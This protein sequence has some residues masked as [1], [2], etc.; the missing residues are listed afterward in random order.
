MSE[1]DKRNYDRDTVKKITSVEKKAKKLPGI[2]ES[3]IQGFWELLNLFPKISKPGLEERLEKF[4]LEATPGQYFT[5][6]C[7]LFEAAIPYLR[8]DERMRSLLK[9]LSGKSCGLA[10]TGKYESTVTFDDL[11]FRIQRGISSKKIPVIS[12]SSRKDYAEVVLG[13][14]DPIKMLIARKIRATHKLTLLKWGLPHVNLLRERDLFEKS[15]TYQEEAEKI[16]DANLAK[17]GY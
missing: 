5:M 6:Q 16:L 7:A 8:E 13:R 3:L 14:K 10:V 1:Q 9:S 11:N 17:M 4:I 2:D 12:I 15:L